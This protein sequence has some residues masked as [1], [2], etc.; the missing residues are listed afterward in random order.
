MNTKLTSMVLLIGALS[1]S[2]A[3]Y[4]EEKM[5]YTPAQYQDDALTTKKVHMAFARDKQVKGLAINV[6]TQQGVV[7][8]NGTVN[9]Q[10][11]SARA[12]QVAAKVE[13][14]IAVHNELT[15]MSAAD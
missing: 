3:V 12:A 6:R 4:A 7:E 10:S 13:S 1:A 2:M 8:L 5:P 9:H 14:V 11:Q 15:V